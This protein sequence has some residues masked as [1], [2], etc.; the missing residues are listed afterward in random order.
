MKILI[1][2]GSTAKIPF[3]RIPRINQI[4]PDST[5]NTRGTVK[6][7]KEVEIVAMAV[8]DLWLLISWNSQSTLVHISPWNGPMSTIFHNSAI[9]TLFYIT[10]LHT[11]L[12]GTFKAGC[13]SH[14]AFH[15]S[16]LM[17]LYNIDL[18]VCCDLF[19]MDALN[20]SSSVWHH[21][22][23]LPHAH[24]TLST[25]KL[26]VMPCPAAD[27]PDK[28][29]KSWIPDINWSANKSSLIW[30]LLSQIEK[31]E[32]YQVLYGKKD[33]S[34]VSISISSAQKRVTWPVNRTQVVKPR[35]LFTTGL[36]GPFFQICMFLI[37]TQSVITSRESSKGKCFND[38]I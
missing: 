11:H 37:P 36:L 14:L 17:G 15:I 32:N 28:A 25:S 20:A 31:D 3:Y 5:R 27:K 33:V 29:T 30:A 19:V 38:Y 4:P 6:N 10:T 8:V 24:L 16:H 35:L 2:A 9:K 7:S 1:L 13:I 23:W 34:K 26:T 18:R 12:I 22:T 21:I